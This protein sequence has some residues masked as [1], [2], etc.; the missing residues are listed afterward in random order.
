MRAWLKVARKANWANFG[1]IRRDVSGSADR[2]QRCIVFNIGGN[3]YRLVVRIHFDR[4][5]LY[6]VGVYSHREYDQD[7]WKG[8]C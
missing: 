3:K 6:I 1:E 5:K 4:S 7:E 2:F 8:E